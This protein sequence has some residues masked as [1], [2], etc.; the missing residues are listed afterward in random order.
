[1]VQQMQ[2]FLTSLADMH[3]DDQAQVTKRGARDIKKAKPT[4]IEKQKAKRK[5]K[6]S[7][8]FASTKK[9]NKGPPMRRTNR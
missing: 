3:V 9:H 7:I 5:S 4:R 8:V 1:M 6:K 2:D